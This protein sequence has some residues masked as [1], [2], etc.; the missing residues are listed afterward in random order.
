MGLG[1]IN[2]L[3]QISGQ[4]DDC[5]SFSLC[6]GKRS[7]NPMD[8]DWVPSV[9]SYKK[10]IPL[11]K[12]QAV[13]CFQKFHQKM[14]NIYSAELLSSERYFYSIFLQLLHVL[15]NFDNWS[16]FLIAALLK[17]KNLSA[18]CCFWKKVFPLFY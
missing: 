4:N 7:D 12:L 2:D 16:N 8:P 3:V 5:S 11:S 6:T 9:F 13:T 1:N 14:Q 10:A 18:I 15:H 17:F